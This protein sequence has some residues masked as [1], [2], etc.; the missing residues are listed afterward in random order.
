MPVYV[1]QHVRPGNWVAL[2][3]DE[4]TVIAADPDLP[5]VVKAPAEA[6][7]TEPVYYFKPNESEGLFFD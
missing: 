1:L 2:S 4:S 7:E 6:G 3:T 5:T